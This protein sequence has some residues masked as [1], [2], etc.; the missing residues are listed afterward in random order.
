MENFQIQVGGHMFNCYI[1]LLYTVC[2]IYKYL[3]IAFRHQSELLKCVNPDSKLLHSDRVSGS[4]SSS[5]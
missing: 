4:D 3:K 2:H 5:K 1:Q